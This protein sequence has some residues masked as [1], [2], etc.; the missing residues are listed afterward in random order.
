ML[1]PVN[2]THHFAGYAPSGVIDYYYANMQSYLAVLSNTRSVIRN[3]AQGR[4]VGTTYQTL[5]KYC[6]HLVVNQITWTLARETSPILAQL[7][8]R[9]TIWSPFA[10]PFPLCSCLRKPR[11]SSDE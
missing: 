7:R 6:L 2:V 1:F 8:K 10:L 11:R 9:A 3:A 4:D 5:L